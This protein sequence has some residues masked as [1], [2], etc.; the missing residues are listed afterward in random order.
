MKEPVSFQILGNSFTTL[1][2][3]M[4]SGLFVG[5][6]IVTP[7]GRTISGATVGLD[8]GVRDASVEPNDKGSLGEDVGTTA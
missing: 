4:T 6:K 8:R 7:L 2:S 5:P 1:V 3:S